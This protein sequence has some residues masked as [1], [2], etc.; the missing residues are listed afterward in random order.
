MVFK[1][2]RIYSIQFFI[3]ILAFGIGDPQFNTF[4]GLNYAFNGFG[5]FI[6]TKTIDSSFEIQAETE[7]FAN[8]NNPSISGTFFRRFVAK[9]D[10]SPIVEIALSNSKSTNPYLSIHFYL[11]LK[12]SLLSIFFN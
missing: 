5:Q 8:I 11:K 2:K 12:I 6:L 9:K 7:I 1:G 4:D 10:S 3:F